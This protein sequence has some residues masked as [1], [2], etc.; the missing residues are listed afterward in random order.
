MRSCDAQHWGKT[1]SEGP[2]LRAIPAEADS[3]EPARSPWEGI[4][5]PTQ[6]SK[7][8]RFLTDVIVELGLV[9]R[10]RVDQAVDTARGAGRL[11]EQVLLESG[12]IDAV[13]LSRAVAERH[14]L[15][16]L[17]LAVFQVDMAA[18]NLITS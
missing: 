12:A 14:G 6:G 1:M 2:Y 15:E 9:S 18:A 3:A 8:S 11:P 16:H 5:R 17:D 13:G 4:T 7:R 10:E